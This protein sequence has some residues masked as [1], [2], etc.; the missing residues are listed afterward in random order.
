MAWKIYFGIVTFI[1]LFSAYYQFIT[2]SYKLFDVI[3]LVSEIILLVGAYGYIFKKKIFS[4]KNW[5]LIFKILIALLLIN[6]LYQ[7]WPSNYVGDFSLLNAGLLTNIFV[8]LLI[9][10]LF[11][12]LYYA[13]YKLSLAKKSTKKKS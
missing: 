11:I 10:C 7:V 13:V 4:A 9:T 2:A 8:Y 12:P 6:I 3:N 1:I 5:S